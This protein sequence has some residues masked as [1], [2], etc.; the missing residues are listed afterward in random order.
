MLARTIKIKSPNPNEN[1]FR[2][3]FRHAERAARTNAEV[4]VTKNI[5][6]EALATIRMI[7]EGFVIIEEEAEENPGEEVKDR[8]TLAADFEGPALI[9][10]VKVDGEGGAVLVGREGTTLAALQKIFF[11]AL[12]FRMGGPGSI[13]HPV[14]LEVNG[15][16]PDLRQ[17]NEERT[18]EPAEPPVVKITVDAPEGVK[19]EVA[20]RTGG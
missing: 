2:T 9:V 16:R 13:H 5:R 15:R 4:T 17:K 11:A 1:N 6:T 10:R 14:W 7:L 20:T 18:Q 12:G 19:V 3:L 8:C